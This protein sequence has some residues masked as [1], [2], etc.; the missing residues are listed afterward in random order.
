MEGKRSTWCSKDYQNTKE[1]AYSLHNDTEFNNA[2]ELLSELYTNV[3][4]LTNK[5]DEL[6]ILISSLHKK[7]N[8]I[9]ITEVNSKIQS[10]MQESEYNLL[11]FDLYSS[12]IA[13]DK[14]RGIIMYIDNCLQSCELE[15]PVKFNECLCVQIKNNS[16]I[17]LN[18][19]TVY[20][21]PNSTVENDLLLIELL[22]W[23]NK[24]FPS[25]LL[26]MGDF[27]FPGINWTTWTAKSSNNSQENKFLSGIRDNL[28]LQYVQSPT[29][30]RGAD[31]ANIL[32]LVLANEDFVG[33]ILNL[34]PLGKSDHS[35]LQFNCSLICNKLSINNRL[36]LNK[37]DFP[38]LRTFL[39][40][41]WSADFTGCEGN[42]DKVWNKF[43]T[44]LFDGIERF[45]PIVSN[46]WKKKS[47]WNRP[48]SKDI[49]K[50]IKRKHRLWTRYQETRDPKYE[51]EYK[52]CRNLVRKVTRNAKIKE[53]ADV[54]N[55]CKTNP[56]KFWNYV[57]S[58][59]VK[60]KGVGDLKVI[61]DNG[62]EQIL[63][64]DL[65]KASAF[66]Q[67]F[68]DVFTMET[69][70]EFSSL[71]RV[72][73]NNSMSE[74]ILSE[75]IILDELKKLKVDKS[76]GPDM[77]HPRILQEVASQ[78]S[79]PL[80]YIFDLSLGSGLLPDDWKK[81]IVSVIYKKGSKS[82][83]SNY[84]PI[85]LTCIV[86]KLL[87]SVIRNH[88][89][90]Y[91]II[92]HLF[93]SRQYGFIKGRS[94]V[95][96]LLNLVNLWTKYLENKGQIDIIYTDFE[97]AFDKVPHK[98]L[99]SKLESYRI[100][101]QLIVWIKSFLCERSYCVK[102]NGK[103]S[104][105]KEMTSGIPQGSVIGP[106][107]FVIFINDL[108]AFVDS[109]SDIFL[110]AD[111]A[112]MYK[113]ISSVQDAE[114]LNVCCEQLFSWCKTWLMKLNVDKCKV[115]SLRRSLVKDVTYP[116]GFND[117][118]KGF[119]QLEH[120][121]EIKDL[122]VL[123]DHE[124]SFKAHIRDKINKAYMMLGIIKR[125]FKSVDKCSFKLLYISLV[126]SHL[127]YAHSV[128]NPH[129]VS[130]IKDIEKVQKRA[131]KMVKGCKYLGY[132]ERLISLQLPTLKY[133]RVRGDM[134]EVYKITHGHYDPVLCPSLCRNEDGRTRGNSLKLKV[135]RAKIDLRKFSFC[136]RT[137]AT[138]NSLPDSV[139]LSESLNSFKKNLDEFWKKEDVVYDWKASL[140]GDRTRC[141]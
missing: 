127:E 141:L 94:T 91:F 99:I 124:L 39:T 131:T 27:N 90:D 117:S 54:A 128:W 50:I 48:L 78:I 73:V 16:K 129:A 67:Y 89:M 115:L 140:P 74:L 84:R 26:I 85:S 80:L 28:F 75:S 79:K 60:K 42:V 45:I 12:N 24:T 32:D 6:N 93:S 44:I 65:E 8:I 102:V 15:L 133:R 81:S 40:R 110:F 22:T 20:R 62:I 76:P 41:E 71:D 136:V 4:S 132:R 9:S 121:D 103:Y 125:N 55:A 135:E 10:N 5:R 107:L 14:C 109:K 106:L 83:V 119:K 58:K 2:D 98:R 139:V 97:K 130:L 70:E 56:K 108:P 64:D 113:F 34:S 68:S 96:Q 57:Q 43:K 46:N 77:I 104:E 53:Q 63:T 35:V 31:T 86:C 7:P 138:W 30:A 111:D 29:R 88:V 25:S 118:L 69:N 122:G 49:I 51:N 18:I 11:G 3:D 52:K 137:I 126:R 13:K 36:N 82:A 105:W 123:L 95:L 38:R 21:S 112:K 59:T 33:E 72:N 101:P 66:V 100:T 114:E 23:L 1:V 116:Y 47:S 19:V 92:N 134:I 120:V 17:I 37:G 87:E 61:D